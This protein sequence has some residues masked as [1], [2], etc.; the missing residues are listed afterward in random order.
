M[1]NWDLIDEFGVCTSTKD[2]NDAKF[3]CEKLNIPFQEINFVKD[4][5]TNVFRYYI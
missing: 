2:L 3:V 5:W 1:K 4:Y